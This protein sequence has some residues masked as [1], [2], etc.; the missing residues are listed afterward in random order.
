[1]KARDDLAVGVD[2][3]YTQLQKAQDNAK[4][5][6]LSLIHIYPAGVQEFIELIRW[7]SKEKG[8]TVLFSSHHLDQVQNCLLYTSRCV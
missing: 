8:L 2:K 5:L 1:M 4:A 7:L 3:L 6:N